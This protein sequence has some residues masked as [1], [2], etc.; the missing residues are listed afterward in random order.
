[1]RTRTHRWRSLRFEQLEPRQ[2]LA[3]NQPI[4][5]LLLFD[6]TGSFSDASNTLTGAFSSLI[7]KLSTS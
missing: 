7:D 4:D 6:D 5:I 2:M 1:M 3:A